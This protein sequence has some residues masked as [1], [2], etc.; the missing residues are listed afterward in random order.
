MDYA[1]CIA[2]TSRHQPILNIC[3]IPISSLFTLVSLHFDLDVD[4]VYLNHHGD[5]VF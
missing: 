5:R 4:I 1:G 3:T 2:A